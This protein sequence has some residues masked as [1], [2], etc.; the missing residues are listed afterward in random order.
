MA[1]RYEQVWRC[2]YPL[3]RLSG[4]A[5]DFLRAKRAD[6][7]ARVRALPAGEQFP[8]DEEPR[9]HEEYVD[10]DEP[11]AEAR[12]VQVGEDYGR[13]RHGAQAVHVGTVS[14]GSVC[15]GAICVWPVHVGATGAGPRRRP[16][17]P[18]SLHIAADFHRP[19]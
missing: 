18:V 16:R 5:I 15:A 2:Y 8:R 12:D 11:A 17:V 4:R 19:S 14:V 9:D 1:G 13:D 10:P 7:T 6:D 3:V